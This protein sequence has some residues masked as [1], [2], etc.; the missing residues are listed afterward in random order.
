MRFSN[1]LPVVAA[2]AIVSGPALAQGTDAVPPPAESAEPAPGAA[3]TAEQQAQHDAWPADTQTY[4]RSLTPD[5][6]ALFWRISDDNKVALTR[7]PPEQQ[8]QA[9]TQIESQ[10][11]AQPAEPAT[12]ADPP[13]DAA[14]PTDEPM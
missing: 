14:A 10:A 4:F 5:R 9:W 1:W 13:A 7:L 8:A 12:T 3:L 6:Q 2:T 11:S